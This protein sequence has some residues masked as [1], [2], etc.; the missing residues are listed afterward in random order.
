MK[1]DNLKAGQHTLTIKA[2]DDHIVVD[3]WMV[4]YKADRKFYLFPVE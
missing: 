2:L 3:Q 4:D 1:L